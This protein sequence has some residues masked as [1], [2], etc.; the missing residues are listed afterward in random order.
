MEREKK[1]EGKKKGESGEDNG[2]EKQSKREK[3]KLVD[4]DRYKRWSRAVADK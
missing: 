3:L 2:E 1:K 4:T